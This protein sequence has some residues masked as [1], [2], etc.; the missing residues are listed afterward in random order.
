MYMGNNVNVAIDS[1][2]KSS[3]TFIF[4]IIVLILN[5]MRFLLHLYSALKVWSFRC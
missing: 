1:S 5:L 4:I 2:I 3:V